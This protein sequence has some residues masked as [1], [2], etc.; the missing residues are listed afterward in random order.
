MDERKLNTTYGISVASIVLVVISIIFVILLS[1]V[2]GNMLTYGV[3]IGGDKP[4]YYDV[5]GIIGNDYVSLSQ[6][7]SKA[8]SS[9]SI[10][11]TLVQRTANSGID[12]TE[13]KLGTLNGFLVA[14]DG[15]VS[16]QNDASIISVE[17][18]P[19]TIVERDTSGFG[20]FVGLYV[21][22]QNGFVI[23]NNGT[24]SAGNLDNLPDNSIPASKVNLSN[25]YTITQINTLFAPTLKFQP[26]L[27]K[28]TPNF[29]WGFNFNNSINPTGLIYN[30]ST[31]NQVNS[32]NSQVNLW[33]TDD[34]PYGTYW[35]MGN[36]PVDANQYKQNKL[37]IGWDDVSGAGVLQ[38]TDGNN[39]TPRP[40]FLQPAGGDIIVGGNVT[41]KGLFTNEDLVFPNNNLILYSLYNV[42]YNPDTGAQT[43]VGLQVPNGCQ[44]NVPIIVYTPLNPTYYPIDLTPYIGVTTGYAVGYSEGYFGCPSPGMYKVSINNTSSMNTFV[45]NINY[46]YFFNVSGVVNPDQYFFIGGNLVHVIVN[47]QLKE[48]KLMTIT[49]TRV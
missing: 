30:L 6:L 46:T 35:V 14:S 43:G 29:S 19:N 16:S 10:P 7:N 31:S 49:I 25:Y 9:S 45:I 18:V 12:I 2:I 28:S 27:Y 33:G 34:N 11:G 40:L 39:K 13:L 42:F 23:A 4:S 37:V 5:G 26:L 41:V 47:G 21:G 22:N 38:A 1:I 48:S 44:A 20:K 3:F 15:V 36:I 17:P 8:Y 24:Y 32:S